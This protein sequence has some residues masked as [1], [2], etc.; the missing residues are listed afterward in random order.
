MGSKRRCRCGSTVHRQALRCRCLNFSLTFTTQLCG[1]QTSQCN[2]CPSLFQQLLHLSAHLKGIRSQY[3]TITQDLARVMNRIKALYRSWA[4]ACSV[5]SVY[6]P[7]HRAEWLDKIPEPGVRL[8]A[9]RFYQQLDLL[10][11]VRQQARRDLLTESRKHHAVKLLRQIPSIGPIRAALLVAQLQIP[12]RFR[13]KPCDLASNRSGILTGLTAV[14][15]LTIAYDMPTFSLCRSSNPN[16]RVVWLK[17]GFRQFN[18]QIGRNCFSV[19]GI[20]FTVENTSCRDLF[21]RN[22][23]RRVSQ[24]SPFGT[25]RL[26]L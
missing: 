10:Q 13:T 22:Q 14:H 12:H 4:I 9:K 24:N 8:P 11:P 23:L 15:L 16:C 21:S 20:F 3:V 6:A 17:T 5:T 7:R 26:R 25:K 2:G 1:Q 19:D 18:L